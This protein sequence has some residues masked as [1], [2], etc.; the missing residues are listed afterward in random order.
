MKIL[1]LTTGVLVGVLMMGC[2]SGTKSPR[3][4]RLP[5]GNVAKGQDAFVSLQCHTCHDVDGVEL[6]SP[7]S[8]APLLLTLGGEVNR[9]K[10]YGELVTSLINPTHRLSADFVGRWTES[11]GDVDGGGGAGDLSP[12][13]Q[14]NHLMTVEQMIDLVAFLQSR[15]K[16][17]I[18]AFDDY[19]P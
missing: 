13:S 5:D 10:T 3:G 16:L 17:L 19:G 15:Y 14:F 6:P 7:A 18:P 4:F 8:P 1:T 2:D 12:M 9:V 11:R